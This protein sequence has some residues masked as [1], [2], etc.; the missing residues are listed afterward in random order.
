MQEKNKTAT[1]SVYID[2]S[3]DLGFNRGT[4]WFVISAV[5]VKKEH[6]QNIR[7]KMDEI[8]SRLNI[9]EI[10]FHKIYEYVRR[11]YVVRELDQFE[12]AYM[13]IIVDTTKMDKSK[14]PDPIIAYNYACKY[15]LQRV[16]WYLREIGETADIVLSA[17]GTSR[18]GDLITYIQ[19]KLLPYPFNS[20]HSETI[21]KVEAKTAASWDL[22]QLADVCAT[23]MFLKYE[24][25]QYGFCTPCFAVA[26]EP[27]LY[28]RNGK[29]DTYGIKFFTDQMRPDESIIHSKMICAKKERTPGATTT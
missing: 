22:L 16:T 1:Y 29:I 18:D 14:I 19:E 3:G 27:H 26:L 24:E 20:I 6:E 15:L 28:R 7:A 8:K 21:N 9:C 23:T 10:H 5:V 13:N 4:H 17:R 11:A 25:N 2:E 12:F